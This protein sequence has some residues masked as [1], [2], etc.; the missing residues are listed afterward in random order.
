MA[1]PQEGYGTNIRCQFLKCHQRTEQDPLKRWRLPNVLPQGTVGGV[2]ATTVEPTRHR[3][4]LTQK[5]AQIQVSK[6]QVGV[7]FQPGVEPQGNQKY[8]D[9][10]AGAGPSPPPPPPPEIPP[11][12]QPG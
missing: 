6:L 7:R 3:C 2:I 10:V 1:A 11:P 8:P 4:E 9:P 5:L 12:E